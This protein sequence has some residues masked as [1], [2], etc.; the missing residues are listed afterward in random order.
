MYDVIIIGARCAGSPTAMLLA[1]KG[2]KVLLVDK[3]EFP[4]DTISTHII[5]PNGVER[6]KRWRLLDKVMATN[7][8]VIHNMGF[9]P[10]PFELMGTPPSPPGIEGTVAPRRIKLDKILVDAAVE[11]GAELRENCIAEE[12]TMS[13]GSVTGI[14]CQSKGGSAITEKAR[15]VI[16]ADGRNSI[17]AQSVNAEKYNDQP[18][19]TCWYYTYWSGINAKGLT[20]YLRPNRAFGTIPTNDGLTCIP[21]IATANEFHEFRS[22]IEGN[23]MKTLE[24]SDEFADLVR[25][26]KREDRFY[27]MSDVPNFFRKSFGPGWALAGD[28]GYHKDPITGQGISDAFYAA[29]SLA[30]AIDAGFSGKEILETALAQYEKRRDEKSLP[31]YGLTCEWATLQPPPPELQYLLAALRENKTETDNFFGAL[32]GTVSIPEFYSPENIQRIIGVAKV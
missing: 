14:R 32:A 27:G 20:L 5:F 25:Q 4:S 16:G 12:I 18:P 22:D 8:P 29:E 2:Y 31:M 1:R 24:L 9:N 30:E 15:I 6:L 10:G 28:A 3:A 26:G 11:A 7:C 17:L 21:V 19:L 23:Y 13:D